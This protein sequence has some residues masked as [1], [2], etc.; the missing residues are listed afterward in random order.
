LRDIFY[1]AK[2]PISLKD[3]FT[4]LP[5]SLVATLGLE[6]DLIYIKR[7]ISYIEIY[8]YDFRAYLEPEEVSELMRLGYQS[9]FCLTY[10]V[11]DF[12]MCLSFIKGFMAEYGGVMFPDEEPLRLLTADMI[13]SFTE[14]EG[15]T[16]PKSD[17]LES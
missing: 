16:E 6:E 15:P 14:A 1:A 13:D 5:L 9:V 10:K 11:G 2:A 3:I 17:G 12:D 7:P 4:L 8:T